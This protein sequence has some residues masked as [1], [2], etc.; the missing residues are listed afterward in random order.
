MLLPRQDLKPTLAGFLIASFI[1][2]YVY[3]GKSS[4]GKQV[5]LEHE[6]LKN[7]VFYIRLGAAFSI[8]TISLPILTWFALFAIMPKIR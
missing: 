7:Q 2:S 8:C 1:I 5:I 4:R 6:K 3:Y